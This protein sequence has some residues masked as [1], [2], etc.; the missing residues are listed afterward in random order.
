MLAQ[1]EGRT[2]PGWRD[3]ERAVAAAF[4]GENQENKFI[5]DVLIADAAKP[6]KYGISCKMR[7]ELN[8][9]DK[10][11]RVTIELSNSSKKF[12]DYLN[13]KGI[14]PREYT[15]RPVEVGVALIELIENW[16]R[17]VSHAQGG[18]IDLEKSGYLTLMYNKSG[19]YQL[20]WFHIKLP[21][22][23]T[24]QWY[25]PEKGDQSILGHLNGDDGQ[26]GR[27]FEWYSESGGQLKYYPLATDAVWA[28]SRFQL[29][30]LPQGVDKSVLRAKA[31]SYFPE[32]WG[33]LSRV[34]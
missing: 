6:V 26:G 24:I 16:K 5:F 18:V 3:F 9:V 8:R 34:D 21:N 17:A 7:S 22:P 30:P 27:L 28:S 12:K 11:G 25:Y 19:F 14:E 23:L 15:A 4:N 2:L 31:E 20:H 29:E 10:D 13:A 33:K 1:P 32:L